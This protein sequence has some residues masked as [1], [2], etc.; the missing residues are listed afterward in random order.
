MKVIERIKCFIWGHSHP[1][2]TCT[3][4]GKPSRLGFKRDEQGNVMRD[5][6]G[7]PIVVKK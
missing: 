1:W 7:V 2:F 3:H 4:C 5:E 6:R